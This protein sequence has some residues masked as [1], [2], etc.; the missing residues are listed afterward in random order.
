M[1]CIGVPSSDGWVGVHRNWFLM[2]NISRSIRKHNGLKAHE[3]TAKLREMLVLFA[4]KSFKRKKKISN[5]Y[6]V[7]NKN[8]VKISILQLFKCH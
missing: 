5:E 7:V 3:E 6:R 1:D 8:H 4:S 2:A